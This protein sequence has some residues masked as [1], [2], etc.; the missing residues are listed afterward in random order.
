MSGNGTLPA[1]E[2]IAERGKRLH[3]EGERRGVNEID[4]G[5]GVGS[6]SGTDVNLQEAVDVEDGGGPDTQAPSQAVPGP[7]MEVTGPVAASS[8]DLATAN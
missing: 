3:Y 8:H 1:L 7:L 2:E 6:R 4:A 5:E